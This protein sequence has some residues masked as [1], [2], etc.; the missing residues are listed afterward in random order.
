MRSWCVTTASTH[1]HSSLQVLPNSSMKSLSLQMLHS[2]R[3]FSVNAGAHNIF[4]LILWVI[5][6]RLKLRSFGYFV[7]GLSRQSLFE[8]HLDVETNL[9]TYCSGVWV[10]SNHHKAPKNGAKCPACFQSSASSCGCWMCVR[11]NR[12][13]CQYSVPAWPHWALLSVIKWCSGRQQHGWKA[14]PVCPQGRG[15][16]DGGAA[17]GVTYSRFCS[18]SCGGTVIIPPMLNSLILSYIN[19]ARGHEI[20]RVINRSTLFKGDYCMAYILTLIYLFFLRICRLTPSLSASSG[21]WLSTFK[22]LSYSHSAC[23]LSDLLCVCM[24]PCLCVLLFPWRKGRREIK[25]P[26]SDDRG[27]SKSE[28]IWRHWNLHG[29][30]VQR[31]RRKSSSDNA[32]LKHKVG[33]FKP[34]ASRHTVLFSLLLMLYLTSKKPPKLICFYKGWFNFNP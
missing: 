18:Y 19:R 29:V 4:H 17:M 32:V 15:W 24:L 16:T 22:G 27:W 28:V 14:A 26:V 1:T 31:F 11:L 9:I 30:H 25:F 21:A 33:L 3:S 2:L 6:L 10:I 5:W 13:R 7:I 12:T 23:T 8:T 34:A 20:L